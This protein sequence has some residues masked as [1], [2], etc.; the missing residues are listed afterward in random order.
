MSYNID[1]CE[2]L[3]FENVRMD[4]ATLLRLHKELEDELP[5]ITFFEDHLEEARKCMAATSVCPKCKKPNDSDAKFCKGCGSN[6]PPAKE[7]TIKLKK[8]SWCG[9]GSGNSFEDVFVKKIAQHIMGKADLVYTW[10]GGDSLSGLR[11]IDG[12]VEECD[13][14]QTLVPKEVPKRKK[15]LPRCSVSEMP[16]PV[17]PRCDGDMWASLCGGMGGHRTEHVCNCRWTAMQK[18]EHAF[19]WIGFIVGLATGQHDARRPDLYPSSMSRK[20]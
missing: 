14:V 19:E 8:L 18:A 3:V 17:C 15:R 1:S 4:A 10:E 2:N 5:E 7:Q 9:E 6:L 13:V 16:P 11:I 20:T 12:K